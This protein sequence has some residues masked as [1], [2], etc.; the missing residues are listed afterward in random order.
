V[1]RYFIAQHSIAL[2]SGNKHLLL[3]F[4]FE[5]TFDGCEIEENMQRTA[6]EFELVILYN[7]FNVPEQ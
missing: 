6:L 3:C 7:M 4:P 1:K 5:L 2:G